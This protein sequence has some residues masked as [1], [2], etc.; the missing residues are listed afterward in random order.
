MIDRP[1]SNDP[2]YLAGFDDGQDGRVPREATGDRKRD[3][4]YQT[5]WSHGR[6]LYWDYLGYPE[7]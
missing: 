1:R 6:A 3:E 5:G 7:T 4:Q 2:D